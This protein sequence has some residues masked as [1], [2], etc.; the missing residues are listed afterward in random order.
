MDNE[1]HGHEGS[2]AEDV[3]DEGNEAQATC[4]AALFLPTQDEGVVGHLHLLVPE[5]H[6]LAQTLL[7]SELVDDEVVERIELPGLFEGVFVLHN[8]VFF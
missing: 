1:A 6:L 5:A 3:R 7:V 8:L 4:P 2:H